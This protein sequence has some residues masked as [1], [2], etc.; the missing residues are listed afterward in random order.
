MLKQNRGCQPEKKQTG[1]YGFMKTYETVFLLAPTLDANAQTEKVEFFKGVIT[2]NGGKIVDE[3]Y[4]GKLNLSYPIQKHSQAFYY[5]VQFQGEGEALTELARRYSYDDDVLRNIVVRIDGKKFK[6]DSK[7]Q[8]NIKEETP[9]AETP[10]T[11]APATAETATEAPA[12]SETATETP[13]TTETA[14][15]ESSE[16]DKSE[17]SES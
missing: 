10:A 15:A 7:V 5:L 6:M 9:A 3:K 17:S 11:E 1:R 12:T 14:T 13:A 8:F 2:K 4:W 16:S